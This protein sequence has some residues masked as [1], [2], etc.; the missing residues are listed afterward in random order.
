MNMDKEKHKQL[1]YYILNKTEEEI[2]E[3]ANSGMFNEII[4]GYCILAMERAGYT[5]E[6]IKELD[7]N[8]LFDETLAGEARAAVKKLV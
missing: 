6:D 7:F 2:N 3:L 8:S 5:N 1:L 4:K